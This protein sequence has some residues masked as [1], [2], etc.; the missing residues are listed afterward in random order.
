MSL[1]GGGVS[2]Y[3]GCV[4]SRGAACRPAQAACH[5]QMTERRHFTHAARLGHANTS[6]RPGTSRTSHSEAG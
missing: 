4:P 3:A 1:H 6:A 2:L 5:D